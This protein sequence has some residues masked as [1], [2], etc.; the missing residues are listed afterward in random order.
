MGKNSKKWY[1]SSTIVFGI[2]LVGLGLFRFFKENN[3]D[4]GIE[5]ILMGGGFIGLRN[6]STTITNRKAN[7]GG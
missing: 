6:A 5:L 3:P 2:L 1:Q 4:A 7:P